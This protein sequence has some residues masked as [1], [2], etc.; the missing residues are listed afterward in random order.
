VAETVGTIRTAREFLQERAGRALP[1]DM[2]KYLKRAP[3]LTPMS[4]DEC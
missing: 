4:G 3:K 1:K 2:L